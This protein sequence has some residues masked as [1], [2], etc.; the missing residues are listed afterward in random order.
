MAEDAS[1]DAEFLGQEGT[2]VTGFSRMEAAYG[3]GDGDEQAVAAVASAHNAE[4]GTIFEQIYRPWNG[5]LN[6]RWV[7]NW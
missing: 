3:S 7:R 2:N 5:T 6:T 1:L 4:V